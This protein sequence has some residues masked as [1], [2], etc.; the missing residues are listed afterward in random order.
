MTTPFQP[1]DRPPNTVSRTPAERPIPAPA[2]RQIIET[3]EAMPFAAAALSEIDLTPAEVLTCQSRCVRLDWEELPRFTIVDR[4]YESMGVVFA[5]AIAICPSNSAY[6]A[7][8]GSMVLMGAPKSGY[9]EA[10]FLQPAHFVCGFV[11]SS[12]RTVMTAFDAENREIARVQTPEPNLAG[13]S[14]TAQPNLSLRLSIKNINRVTFHA[15]DG[16]FTLDDFCFSV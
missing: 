1:L 16:Q 9:V 8:S 10:I 5:N 14:S 15:F 3:S 13:S 11:T 4:Q 7:Y 12:R 6:P 2:P